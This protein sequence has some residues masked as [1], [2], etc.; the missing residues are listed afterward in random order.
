MIEHFR[1][2]A[3]I[4]FQLGE[5]LITD[6]I[7]AL[8]ELVKNSYD[9]DA[10]Y[11]KITVDTRSKVGDVQGII[12]VEDDGVGMDEQTIKRGWLTISNSLKRDMKRA[13][14][15]TPK[16]RTPLGDKGLGRLGVQ[17]LGDNVQI[18]TATDVNKPGLSVTFS[19]TDF[20]NMETLDQVEVD[21]EPCTLERRGTKIV[22]AGLK[23]VETWRGT[24]ARNRLE[25]ELSKMISPY[26][27]IKDFMVYA[28]VD[29]DKLELAEISDQ[30]RQASNVRYSINFDGEFLSIYGKLK[31]D[32][33]RPEKKDDLDNYRRFIER[34]DGQA[35]LK[36]LQTKGF[37]KDCNLRSGEDGWFVEFSIRRAL[38]SIAELKKDE[39]GVLANPGP[40]H[41]EIDAFSLKQK[42]GGVPDVLNTAAEYRKFVESLSGVRIFRDGF[43]VRVDQDWLHLGAQWTTAKSYYTL[44]PRNTIGYVA[45]TARHNSRLQETT[46]REGFI[47]NAYYHNFYQLMNTFVRFSQD[48][49][50]FL[51]R[52][53]VDY[54]K[55]QEKRLPDDAAKQSPK[56]LADKM[57]EGLSKAG[58]YKKTVADAREAIQ[59]AVN[60]ATAAVRTA[61]EPTT[62]QSE[63]AND[64]G[65]PSA[66]A[67][68]AAVATE[69]SQIMA[70]MEAYFEEVSKLE[71]TNDILEHQ[72]RL[73]R[74]QLEMLFETVSL[75]LTAEVL[76]HE[77]QN[78]TDQ[79]S[80]RTAQIE[81]HIKAKG[82]N[83]LKLNTFV[84][85]LRTAIQALRK[86]L[87]HLA[88][89]L[90]YVRHKR[91]P[92]VMSS[93]L[94]ELTEYHFGRFEDEEI[95]IDIQ[96][97]EDFQV[98]TNRGKLTQVID[99][100]V[101][102]S[103]YW[104]L[105]DIRLERIK[106][107]FITIRVASPYLYISDNGRGID[108]S[109]EN[110]LFEPF[111]TTKAEGKGR[112]LG[113]FITR[114]LLESEGCYIELSPERNSNDRLNIFELN[115]R[116]MLDGK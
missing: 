47:R 26:K 84:A 42:G 92:I 68:I 69:T 100:L 27:E 45:L 75:G 19:W 44:K 88:P 21:L 96:V 41:A 4:V 114:Q 79:I 40:F 90:R 37:A 110:S 91:E 83:D 36:F 99:N 32:Y 66:E 102:N 103:E 2:H 48:I 93:F 6:V 43:G 76:S 67:A 23:D 59:S 63:P 77:I 10:S 95:A 22:V 18:F 101:L 78:I 11:V 57:K 46:D 82:I 17:R 39:F 106:K 1:I 53:A 108:P 65:K 25:T 14:T 85:Y 74:E 54:R 89:S 3:S 62:E 58:D 113:L 50:G 33:L 31:L 116:G 15:L 56:A 111:I 34:D 60:E 70:T 29:G 5:D 51:G 73:L 115:L 8:V 20:Q 72:H 97:A 28:T 109:V 105:E 35:F 16:G 30:V 9:A 98:L 24:D 64:D 86:Q 94:T 81:K 55:K 52:G 49:Q 104:L 71:L 107:G 112:G 12:T 87:G 38:D 13:G 7:Q 61:K 80:Q